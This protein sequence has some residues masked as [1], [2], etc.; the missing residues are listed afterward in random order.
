MRPDRRLL[1]SLVLLPSVPQE[2]PIDYI[3]PVTPFLAVFPKAR[4]GT[5]LKDINQVNLN[6]GVWSMPAGATFVDISL[7]YY[8]G[9][10]IPPN[11]SSFNVGV[12]GTGVPQPEIFREQVLVFD[13]VTGRFLPFARTIRTSAPAPTFAYNANLYN[14]AGA[15]SVAGAPSAG[16]G[17]F[18][19][20]FQDDYAGFLVESDNDVQAGKYTISVT[21]G[22]S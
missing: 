3:S 19:F 14:D 21:F 20:A 4:G 10:L 9:Y 2:T 17:H 18:S 11:A 13:P 12:V 15:P 22:N 5:P 8:R 7:V 1:K 6:W 16:G